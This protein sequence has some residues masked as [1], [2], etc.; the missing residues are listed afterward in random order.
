MAAKLL[1][2]AQPQAHAVLCPGQIS[3]GAFVMAMD[4]TRLGSA[5]R[6]R[7]RG[8]RRA[9]RERDLRRGGVDVTHG[10]VQRGDIG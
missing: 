1:A 6:T 8:L 5:E 9:H 4:T 2:D 7:R 3:Q 10:E